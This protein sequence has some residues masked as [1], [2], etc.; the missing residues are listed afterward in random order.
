MT[1]H[2]S[3]IRGLGRFFA[4]A[5]LP[6]GAEAVQMNQGDAKPAS[7]G[8]FVWLAS[9]FRDPLWQWVFHRWDA[10][11][12]QNARFGAIDPINQPSLPFV[13]LYYDSR[14]VAKSPEQLGLPLSHRFSK[15]VVTARSGW[16]QD[17]SLLAFKSDRS[18]GGWSHPDDNTFS[19]FANGEA[20]VAD[21]GA[22][23][24]G[25]QYENGLLI[26]GLGQAWR[27]GGH[28]VQGKITKFDDRGE[29]VIV[30]GDATD[31]Y[32]RFVTGEPHLPVDK[33]VRTLVY[34][35]DN[36]HPFVFLVDDAAMADG[37]EHLWEAH[38]QFGSRGFPSIVDVAADKRS[39]VA[40]GAR[41]E[42]KSRLQVLW[43]SDA[44]IDIKRLTHLVSTVSVKTTSVNPRFVTLIASSRDPNLIPTGILDE[45]RGSLE[46]RVTSPGDNGFTWSLHIDRANEIT[47]ER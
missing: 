16:N 24:F 26:D 6:W 40:I 38:Y 47:C 19:F 1:K 25:T 4:E 35:R 33:V 23:L 17:D 41:K 15:G 30:R 36:T 32:A 37:A 10:D 2:R 9:R 46:I 3:R 43:P 21:P 5:L 11:G 12:D 13:I 14:L 31:A 39:L 34:V 27:K 42:G 20:I 45:S 18:L 44:V 8:W 7:R 22:H 28:Q 29:Y